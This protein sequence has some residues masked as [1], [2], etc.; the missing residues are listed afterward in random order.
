MHTVEAAGIYQAHPSNICHWS[1]E[2]ILTR[3]HF[4]MYK[5]S[6]TN[7]RWVAWGQ[8]RARRSYQSVAS[9]TLSF[10]A[11]STPLYMTFVD[12]NKAFNTVPHHEL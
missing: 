11:H 12:F 3:N 1:R 10:K 5:K 9:L 8:P 7:R 2:S 6:A 4:L